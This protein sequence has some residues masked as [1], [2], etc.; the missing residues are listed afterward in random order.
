[1]VILQCC[2][3]E[4]DVTQSRLSSPQR[5]RE[6]FP[7][8]SIL[9]GVDLAVSSPAKLHFEFDLIVVSLKIDRKSQVCLCGI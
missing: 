6:W 2:V 9:D 5:V 8:P 3:S 4:M 7:T 1:M